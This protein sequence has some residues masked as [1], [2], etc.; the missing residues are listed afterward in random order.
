MFDFT[1]EQAI[2]AYRFD[3][4]WPDA[5]GVEPDDAHVCRKTRH[6]FRTAMSEAKGCKPEE[7]LADTNYGRGQNIVDAAERDV[8]LVTPACGT[9]GQRIEGD[10]T[11]DD[12]VFRAERHAAHRPHGHRALR[13]LPAAGGVPGAIQRTRRNH[14]LHLVAG[15]R[16]D[17]GASP[18]RADAG[19]QDTLPN[20]K[21]D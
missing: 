13:E 20:A 12:F 17:G 2:H 8:E 18:H 7:V 5:L 1:D 14:D 15:R 16:R 21:R 3:T 6:N 19:V 4:S 9:A 11:R 10:V